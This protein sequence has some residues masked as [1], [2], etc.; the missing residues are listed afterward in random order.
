MKLAWILATSCVI[1]CSTHDAQAD[2]PVEPAAQSTEPASVDAPRRI[3]AVGDLHGDMQQTLTVFRLAGLIN[4]DGHWSAG[5]TVFVQTG[6]QTDRGP[7]SKGIIELLV[8][9]ETEAEA[10]GGRVV[11]L[12][13]NHEVM[14]V[15]GDWR[16]VTEEDVATY[17]GME[18]RVQAFSPDGA[19]G[20][21]VRSHDAV[22]RVGDTVFVHGGISPEWAAQG[23]DG[24]NAAVRRDMEVS[25]GEAI[26]SQSVLWYRGYATDPED[27][28]CPRL[29][30]AL[31][32][33]AVKRMVVGHTVQ[34]GGGIVTRCGGK[35]VLIDVGIAKH[36][37]GGHVAAWEW[38]DGDSRALTLA[39]TVDL[40]DPE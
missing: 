28:A 29:Q 20:V 8:R 18:A 2:P 1:G 5:D 7:D 33:L 10:A 24:I 13:G 38:V 21:F 37:G 23:V 12:I 14:N 30:T 11:A 26:G 22:A 34:A 25:G 35:V 31:D 27:T 40:P 19:S 4:D 3:I 15:Q 39:G 36:Y 6:D 9:L 17:G 16:Y 32:S